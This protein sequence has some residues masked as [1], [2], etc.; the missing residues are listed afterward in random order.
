MWP[1]ILWDISLRRRPGYQTLS[2]YFG[3]SS[4]TVLVAPNLLKPLAV[5]SYTTVRR[6]AV[7]RDDLKYSANH[8]TRSHFSTCLYQ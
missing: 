4:A 6:F 1:E 7:D 3:I 2:R 5:L 8:K